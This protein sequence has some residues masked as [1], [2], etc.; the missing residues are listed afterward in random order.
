MLKVLLKVRSLGF[1]P[2]K[3]IPMYLKRDNINNRMPRR[4]V[5]NDFDGTHEPVCNIVDMTE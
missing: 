3:I 4:A 2:S 5:K 1:Y